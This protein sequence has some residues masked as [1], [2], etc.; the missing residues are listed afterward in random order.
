MWNVVSSIKIPVNNWVSYTNW[1]FCL[2]TLYLICSVIRERLWATSF[3]NE[4]LSAVNYWIKEF[5]DKYT[6]L[7]PETSFKPKAHCLKHYLQMIQK[8]GLPVK[9]LSFEAK[10]S[11]VKSA[12]HCTNNRKNICQT[13]AKRHQFMMYLR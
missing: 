8:F 7:F 3:I 12:Y 11:Y 9:T 4:E 13:L 6:V 1:K 2:G 10:H 5:Y